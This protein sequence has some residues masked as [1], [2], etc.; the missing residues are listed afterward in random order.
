M[1]ISFCQLSASGVSGGTHG[2]VVHPPC[3]LRSLGS[4]ASF[5]TISMWRF[6]NGEVT[7]AIDVASQ[8]ARSVSC[9]VSCSP[10]LK[11]NNWERWRVMLLQARQVIYYCS[12]WFFWITNP[13]CSVC[14]VHST[15]QAITIFVRNMVVWN[16]APDM[17]HRPETDHVIINGF[18]VVCFWLA[19][20]LLFVHTKL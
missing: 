4:G 3:R 7:R 10:N 17:S 1:C 16:W 18:R 14:A 5:R 13:V 11:I 6:H 19:A 2:G 12:D 20:A 8:G 15:I 9:S